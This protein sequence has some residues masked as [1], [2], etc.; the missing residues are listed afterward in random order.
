VKIILSVGPTFVLMK[1]IQ[2]VMDVTLMIGA[3]RSTRLRNVSRML[4]RFLWF[5]I[6]S[7]IIVLLY[8]KTIEEENNGSGTDTWFRTFYWVLGLYGG[9]QLFF[10]VILR[11]PWFRMQAE[12]ISNFYIVQ[13]VKWVHQERYYVGSNMYERTRD[14][15]KYVIFWFVVGTCKFAFSYFLQIQPMVGPTRTIIGIHN[16]NYRWKDLISQSNH[17]ALTLVALW[18]PVVMIYFLDTQVWYT[19]VSALVGGFNGARMHL[20]E[21]RSLDMLRARFSSLPGAFVKNLVPSRS[22]GHSQMDVNLPLGA[23]KPG[24]PRVD[25][26]RFAPLWNEV[27]LSLREEDLINNREKEWLLM[28]DNKISSG[29]LG[30]QTLVQWPLFLLANKVYVGIDIVKENRQSSQDELWDRIKRDPYLEYAV[31]EAFATLQ[32]VLLDLLNEHGRAWVL[33]IYQDIHQALE[34]SQ[35][36]YKFNFE[37]L[38][39]VV[40]KIAKLTE[41]LVCF[42][43]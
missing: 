35:V 13:F 41:I 12:K 18:A 2:S 3:Y 19:V 38:G 36:Q 26:I 17:N 24:N 37:E 7:V 30:Q 33:E 8:V 43:A 29:A 25:A 34:V 16:V 23:V 39:N 6:L 27:I 1:F 22:G 28:P 20:G 11:V 21:I 42:Q 15:F 31:E 32:T 40:N 5:T 14:Y 10:A 9:L 4:I